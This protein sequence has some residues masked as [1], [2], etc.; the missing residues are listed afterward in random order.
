M[1]S[2][3]K[4]IRK[5][6]VQSVG[7]ASKS[8]RSPAAGGTDSKTHTG[9]RE[10]RAAKGGNST[11]GQ[12]PIKDNKPKYDLGKGRSVYATKDAN[13]KTVYVPKESEATDT[14]K[15]KGLFVKDSSV[16]PP[17]KEGKEAVKDGKPR[18]DLGK[19]RSVYPVKDD[20]GKTIYLPKESDATEAE[21]ERGLFVKDD[22]AGP[23]PKEGKEAVKDGKPRKDL[24]KGR[25]VFPVKND[26]GKTV[27]LPRESEATD[28]EKANGL[29]VKDSSISE[30]PLPAARAAIKDKKPKYDLGKGRSIYPAKDEKGN[31]AYYPKASEATDE[32]KEKGHFV[33]DEDVATPE[34]KWQSVQGA[35]PK[36]DLGKGRHTYPAKD[37][38][39]NLVYLPK[40]EDATDFEKENNLY[41]FDERLA[42]HEAEDRIPEG[43]TQERIMARAERTQRLQQ[44]GPAAPPSPDSAERLLFAVTQASGE[45]VYLPKQKDATTEEIA[46]GRFISDK[47]AGLQQG[48][49]DLSRKPLS[50]AADGTQ[51]W[52]GQSLPPPT[53][54]QQKALLGSLKPIFDPDSGRMLYP[55][56]VEEV[57]QYL[58]L[59]EDATP[60]EII[61]G[62]YAS[63]ATE[64]PIEDFVLQNIGDQTYE[65]EGGSIAAVALEDF[66]TAFAEAPLK[67]EV[68]KALQE[69]LEG[70]NTP[71]Q[72]WLS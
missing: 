24:G 59:A 9:R 10:S 53:E 42:D 34:E 45:V 47:E 56:E 22:S 41:L 48:K 4:K 5:A 43:E 11:D 68:H 14:E 21:K 38:E 52:D 18:K 23:P 58:P 31:T 25:D 20:N 32:E 65:M 67:L 6:L 17:A 30:P 12:E 54:A 62:A 60:E 29:F 72:R 61:E 19:D 33:K 37:A 16:D 26:K 57:T 71:A 46:D 69:Q 7:R 2:K 50:Q 36:Y 1:K 39:G 40:A 3:L 64:Q 28:F 55:V 51:L 44:I 27:Y 15:T 49:P 63:F 66:T 8:S 35:K 70:G 13:G